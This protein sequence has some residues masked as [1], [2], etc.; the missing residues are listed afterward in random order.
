[1]SVTS[2]SSRLPFGKPAMSPASTPSRLPA[3]A[4]ALGECGGN[5]NRSPNNLLGDGVDENDRPFHVNFPYAGEPH[6]GYEHV[7]HGAPGGP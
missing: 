6:Q 3:P 5:A 2:S 7:H 1:M 4:A